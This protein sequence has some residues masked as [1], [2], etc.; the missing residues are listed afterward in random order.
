MPI[1]PADQADAFVHLM[2]VAAA[3][4]LPRFVGASYGG[5]VGMHVA[6]RHPERIGALLAIAAPA[7]RA[8]LFECVP[9]AA[10]ARGA[11]S[12]RVPATPQAGVALARALAMLT[13]RT[14]EEFADRFAPFPRS[15]T[16]HRPRRGRRLPRC[17]KA[18]ATAAR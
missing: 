17:I 5:M 2:D 1:D 13:Y 15:K 3:S 8:S 14:P 16:P 7:S 6:A 18:L 4:G 10:A 11:R 12:A 9:I